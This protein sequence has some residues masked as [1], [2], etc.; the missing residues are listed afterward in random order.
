M[1]MQ[2]KVKA[3]YNIEAA[4]HRLHLAPPRPAQ[5][6]HYREKTWAAKI[7]VFK[8]D[9]SHNSQSPNTLGDTRTTASVMVTLGPTFSLLVTVAMTPLPQCV[10]APAADCAGITLR[11][12]P[13]KDRGVDEPGVDAR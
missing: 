9:C 10:G 2:G 12:I 7:D 1:C 8:I 13:S 5:H 4:T 3:L 11:S 6:V